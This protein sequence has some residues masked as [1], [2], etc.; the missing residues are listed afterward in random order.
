MTPSPRPVALPLRPETIPP[1]LTSLDR[2]GLWSYRWR[3]TR[4]TKE[5]RRVSQRRRLA[6]IANLDDWT[7]FANALRVFQL[8]QK[9][10]GDVAG[11]GFL[12]ADAGITIVDIDGCL[13]PTGPLSVDALPTD[14]RTTVER[15]DS[16][17]ELSPSGRG[18]HVIMRASLSGPGRRRNGIEIYDR[19]RFFAITGCML[20]G[21]KSTIEPRQAEAEALYRELAPAESSFPRTGGEAALTS[22]ATG[23]PDD[24]IIRLASRGGLLGDRFELLFEFAEWESFFRSQSEADLWLIGRIAYFAGPDPATITRVFLKST[25]AQRAKI[26]ARQDYL[27]KT[28]E[29]AIAG[30]TRF[31]DPQRTP[32]L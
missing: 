18:L 29:K 7:T 32:K 15:L 17:T 13:D 1:E 6:S 26:T 2:W 21:C 5:P 30:R 14:A 27:R 4:W 10:G 20:D 8:D 28:V 9:T 3:G 19:S 12:L 22:S 25:L 31:F 11:I 23:L 16:F 24:E